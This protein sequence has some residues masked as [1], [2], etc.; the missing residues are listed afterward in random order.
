[1]AYQL[2]ASKKFNQDYEGKAETCLYSF[3]VPLPDQLGAKWA[4][5]QAIQAHVAELAKQNSFLLEYKLWEDKM[6]GTLTTDYQVEVTASS[7]PLYWN[8]IILGVLALLALIVIG[9]T[10]YSIKE[11]ARY[12]PQAIPW[13]TVGAIAILTI[14][15]IYLVRRE[16]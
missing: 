1:M 7:S 16:T 2:V 8:L 13:L 4:A 10:I 12:T 6:S 11:I 15:G 5:E 9:W 14:L 3:T